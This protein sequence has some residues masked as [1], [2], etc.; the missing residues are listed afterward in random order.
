[1]NGPIKTLATLELEHHLDPICPRDDHRMKFE[2][3]GIAWK[4]TPTNRRS[5]ALPSYHCN[6]EGCSVR[7]D[8]EH[9]YFSEVLTPDHPYFILGFL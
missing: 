3:A 2:T 9:G 7:Y 4:T 6:F 5:H 8:L 1:M